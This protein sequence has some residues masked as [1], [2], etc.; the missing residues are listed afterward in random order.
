M[1]EGADSVA[2]ICE[3]SLTTLKVEDNPEELPPRTLTTRRP[4]F[5]TGNVPLSPYILIDGKKLRS[6][7]ALTKKSSPRRV[8]FP[9]ND[10]LLVTGYLEP[11]NPWKLGE[12]DASTCIHISFSF[13]FQYTC[14]LSIY[15]S[16]S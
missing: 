1:S 5:G 2:Q 11:A 8:S 6:S 14:I 4:R 12:N 3:N 16:F 10:N 15:F 7:L 13:I 9:A